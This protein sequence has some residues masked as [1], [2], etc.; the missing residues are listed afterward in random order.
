MSS[1][2]V[3]NELAKSAITKSET[4]AKAKVPFQTIEQT[5]AKSE[6]IVEKPDP[7]SKKIKK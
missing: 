2:F 3:I 6:L 4:K 7:S 1:T 5:V